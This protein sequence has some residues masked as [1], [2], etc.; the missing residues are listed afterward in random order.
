MNGG[1]MFLAIISSIHNPSLH[2]YLILVVTI[3][4]AADVQ[5]AALHVIINCVCAPINRST[6]FNRGAGIITGSAKKL[7][8]TGKTSEDLINRVWSCI[9]SNNGIM[10]LL[11]LLHIKIPL[12]GN[13][14]NNII[15]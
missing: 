9:R 10:V 3:Q 11:T 1:L 7:K 14:N 13:C 4:D 5:R 8:P 12:T 15:V 2:M 6:G